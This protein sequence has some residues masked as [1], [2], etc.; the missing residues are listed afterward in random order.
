MGIKKEL[1]QNKAFWGFLAVIIILP[2]VSL[3]NNDNA[4]NGHAIQNIAYM[5]AAIS[6]I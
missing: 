4:M 2:V 5:E 1:I 6:Y 3:M